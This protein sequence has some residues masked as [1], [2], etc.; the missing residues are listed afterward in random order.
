MRRKPSVLKGVIAGAMGG[1][2]ASWVM[3]QF[4]GLVAKVRSNGQLQTDEQDA[5]DATMKTAERIAQSVTGHGL[6]KEQKKKAGPIVHYAY[7]TV[8]G[9]LYGGA[10]SRLKPAAA[11]FGTAYGAAA[12]ALGDEI[13]VPAFNLGS[14]NGGKPPL[15]MHLQELG[16]HLVYGATLEGVRRLGIAAMRRI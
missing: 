11:G 10:A 16:A 4:E 8:I 7:G 1:L 9:A 15:G 14:S 12:W 3:G 13:A 5:E 2:A 6:S